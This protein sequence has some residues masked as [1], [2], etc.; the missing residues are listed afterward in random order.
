MPLKEARI[1][2]LDRGF[3][4]GDGVYELIPV[5]KQQIFCLDAHIKRL[6]NSLSS[7]YMENPFSLNQWQEIL[8]KLIKNNTD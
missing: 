6:D 4:F 5:Y 2:V 3:T 1:S 8:N 7:I